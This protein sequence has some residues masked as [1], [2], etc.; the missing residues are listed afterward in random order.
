MILARIVLG[1][2]VLVLAGCASP[3][4]SLYYWGSYEGQ[5]YALYSDAGQS[6]ITEQ[7]IAMEADYQR[8][9]A[10][11]KPVPPGFHAHLGLLYFQSGKAN[12]A[13]Q[14]FETEKALYPESATF[15]DR[16]IGKMKR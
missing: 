11:N 16:L 12:Q 1:L 5:L 2:M 7:I 13:L 9:S 8:A 15:M 3:R 6:L 4:P 10:A 14:S